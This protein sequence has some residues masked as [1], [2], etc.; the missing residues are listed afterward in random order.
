MRIVLAVNL[1]LLLSTPARAD[2]WPAW[3]GPSGA[4]VSH[5]TKLPVTWSATENVRWKTPLQGA[6][7]SAPIVWGGRVFLT[8]SD[9]RLNDRLH[10][11]CFDAATGKRSWSV[12]FFGSAAPEGL[13]PPGGMAVP[14]P[15]TDG[16][17]V[18]ALFG[19]GDLVCVDFEG[20]PVWIRSLAQEYGPFRNRWGMAAS[21]ILLGDNLIVQVDH[22]GESYLLAVDAVTGKTR[23]RTKRDA[24][25]N[26]TSP[27]VVKV[28][29]QPRIIVSGTNTLRAYDAE[30]GKELW[31]REGMHTQ[32]IPTPVESDGRLYTLGG[33][34]HY[35]LC[36]TM[37]GEELW[38]VRSPGAHIPS[39]L[40][41]GKRFYY[42]ED[43]GWGV[44]LNVENGKRVWRERLGSKQQ[45]SPVAGDGKLYFTG[46]TGII[47]VVKMDDA[48]EEL[49]RNDIGEN[50]VASPAIAEGRLFLRG[51][52]HL[53]CIGAK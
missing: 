2:N 30:T 31:K 21:P 23:W 12:R 47:T 26:W 37:T 5:E 3:R 18:F 35:A 20:K 32:C 8:S 16:K 1:C 44:S 42:A 17:R 34:D 10:L 40:V 41:A 19:T 53:F 25:V 4:G 14:T 51:D 6:G 38:K 27:L 36:L 33:K 28:S 46:E 22:F 9:G 15:A 50:V 52:K 39:P 11:S 45:A 49:A 7:V 43:G 29:D 24:T 48:F 13:F